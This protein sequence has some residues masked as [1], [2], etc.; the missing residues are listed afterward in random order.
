VFKEDVEAANGDIIPAGTYE[1]KV[2]G[3]YYAD[4]GRADPIEAAARGQAWS[5][6]ALGLI[7]QLGVGTTTASA[8]QLAL[9]MA[10]LLAGIGLAV[11]FTGLGL[12]WVSAARLPVPAES[13]STASVTGTAPA[14]AIR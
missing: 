5:P 8:L 3:R 1:F 11:I 13:V 12:I 2:D 6:T 9:A 7:G 14:P 10:G 4:F